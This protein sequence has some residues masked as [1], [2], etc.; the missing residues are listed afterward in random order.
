MWIKVIDMYYTKA[1]NFVG[2]NYGFDDGWL[3]NCAFI[4]RGDSIY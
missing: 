4:K 3:N 1:S 2:Q